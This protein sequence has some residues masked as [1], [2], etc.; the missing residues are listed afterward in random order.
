[1]DKHFIEVCA[2]LVEEEML[3]EIAKVEPESVE[4]VVK[5]R[6]VILKEDVLELHL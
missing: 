3:N 5:E 4:G 2:V 1:M 6:R